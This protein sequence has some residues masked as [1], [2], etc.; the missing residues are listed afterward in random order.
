MKT[1]QNRNKIEEFDIATGD[2]LLS[3][4]EAAIFLKV[5]K[6]FIYEK[7]V[8]ENSEI[9]ALKCGKYKRIPRSSLVQYLKRQNPDYISPG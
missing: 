2:E 8:G 4:E 5:P 3:V 7:S 9:R 1:V 6:N